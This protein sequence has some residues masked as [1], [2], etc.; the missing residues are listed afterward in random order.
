MSEW[1]TRPGPDWVAAEMPPGYQTRLL[2]IERLIADLEQ[3][4]RFARLL[5]QTGSDLAEAVRDGFA[6]LKFD[7]EVTG[8]SGARWVVVRLDNRRRLLVATA[9]TAGVIERKSAELS[10]AFK[11]L[12]EVAGDADRVVL[13]TN[14]DATKPP[15][16]RPPALTPDALALLTRMDAIHLPGPTLFRMWKLSHESLEGARV[17]VTRL[18]EE[19]AGTFELPA[20]LLRLAE[21][22][23]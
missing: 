10:H 20:S 12:Q 17:Q 8:D 2:E 23:L 3:M 15:A 19:E 22:K 4:G 5:W 7:A 14:V 18:H 9:A 6:A 16:E 21:M 13:V 1:V 11:L